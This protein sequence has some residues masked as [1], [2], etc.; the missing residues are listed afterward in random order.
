MEIEHYVKNADIEAQA[1]MEVLLLETLISELS[2]N[3]ALYKVIYSFLGEKS[4]LL[5]ERNN[6]FWSKVGNGSIASAIRSYK[7]SRDS[8]QKKFHIYKAE[9]GIKSLE[10]WLKNNQNSSP[11]DRAAAENIIKDLLN[12]IA[13]S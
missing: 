4:K 7:L 2:G 1:Q 3:P 11:G 13:E 10:L 9:K 8:A 5:W 6:E 12:S